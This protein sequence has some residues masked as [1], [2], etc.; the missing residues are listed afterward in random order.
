[1]FV[2]AITGTSQVEL[3]FSGDSTAIEMGSPFSVQLTLRFDP[4]TTFQGSFPDLN[5]SIG[6]DIEIMEAGPWDTIAVEPLIVMSRNWTL[7]A[8][9]TGTLLLETMPLP[10]TYNFISDTAIA[11]DFPLNI[12]AA[13]TDQ[14]ELYPIKDLERTP[15]K[16]WIWLWILGLVMLATVIILLIRYYYLRKKNRKIPEPEAPALPQIRPLDK[17][18]LALENLRPKVESRLFPE[19]TFYVELSK[20]IKQYLQERTHNNVTG[21]TSTETIDFFSK[22]LSAQALRTLKALLN[23]SDMVKFANASTEEETRKTA[24]RISIDWLKSTDPTLWRQNQQ[25]SSE[26]NPS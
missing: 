17:A 3:S 18:I 22:I 10:Y 2:T 11:K 5:D 9:D 12:F 8:F 26:K 4:E 20:I 25:P 14:E 16:S 7:M 6:F 15:V 23:Q 1:M 24:I 19:D 21:W 13:P